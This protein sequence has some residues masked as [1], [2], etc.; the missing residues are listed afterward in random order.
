MKYFALQ[1]R[2]SNPLVANQ[3]E[4]KKYEYFP[5][6]LLSG[7]AESY[8]GIFRFFIPTEKPNRYKILLLCC[9]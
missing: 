5:I 9:G 8:F 7:A 6:S 4:K 3:R 1:M 2:N